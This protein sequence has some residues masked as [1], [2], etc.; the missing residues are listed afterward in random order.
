MLQGLQSASFSI[1]EII[2]IALSLILLLLLELQ[3]PDYNSLKPLLL[4]SDLINSAPH[5]K[6]YINNIFSSK[7]SP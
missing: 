4:S 2:F 5:V 3:L 1:N 7:E 6:F